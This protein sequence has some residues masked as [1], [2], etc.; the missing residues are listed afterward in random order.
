MAIEPQRGCGYRKV[1]GL[2]LVTMGAGRPCGKLPIRCG[3][4]P[5]CH[6]GIKPNRGW[7]WIDPVP[8]F[9]TMGC[10]RPAECVSCPLAGTN[11]ANLGPI[12]LIW[13]GEKFYPKPADFVAEAN[14]LGIS[15]RI[16]AVPKGLHIGETWVCFAH[17]K[18]DFP[19]MA[20]P[21]PGLFYLAK[22]ERL[23]K[24]VTESQSRD[25]EAMAKLAE[26]GITPVV[27]PDSDPDH[28]PDADQAEADLDQIEL[29]NA[30]E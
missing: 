26:R 10:D 5:T 19:R 22:P 9:G 15:R 21:G 23:E 20:E 7:T 17:R 29:F 4:C 27:V 8:L 11:L 30:A 28:N 6:G 1:G 16:P 3:V 14:R 25:L 12:G 13:V 2:Y 18:V 24:I